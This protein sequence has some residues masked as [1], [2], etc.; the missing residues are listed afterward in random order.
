MFLLSLLC[1]VKISENITVQHFQIWLIFLSWL[2][3]SSLNSFSFN[4]K[5][6]VYCTLEEVCHQ[7]QCFSEDILE[8]FALFCKFSRIFL[9]Q[10]FAKLVNWERL[11]MYIRTSTYSGTWNSSILFFDS[12]NCLKWNSSKIMKFSWNIPTLC[13]TSW[14]GTSSSV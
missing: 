9:C 12:H 7:I 6:T 4:T 14:D 1:F 5:T 10:S 3:F 8:C 13:V 11:D 2:E